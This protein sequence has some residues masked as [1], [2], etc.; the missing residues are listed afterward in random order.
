V[1]MKKVLFCGIALLFVLTACGL[2]DDGTAGQL[3]S[4]E[5][6]FTITGSSTGALY[7]GSTRQFVVNPKYD[8]TWTVEGADP[9]GGTAITLTESKRGR[10]TVGKDETNRTL[11]VKATSVENPQDF[12]TVTVTIDGIPAVWTELT[13]GLKGLITNRTNGFYWF[14]VGVDDASFGIRV[15]AYGD[16]VGTG[17]G[18]WVLGGGSDLREGLDDTGNGSHLWPVM[19]YSDDDGGTWKEIHTIPA[20]LYEENTLC[21]IYDGPPDDRKFVLSTD[22][23]NVFWSYD[24]ITWTKFLQVHPGYAPANTTDRIRQVLYG[25]IDA[26]GGKGRYLTIGVDSRFTWSD[27]GGKTWVQHY[28]ATD[29]RYMADCDSM[30]VKYGT[31]INGGK[32]VKMFFGAGYLGKPANGV[33]CYSLDGINWV[34]LEEANVA[35]VAFEPNPPAGANKDISWKDE[36]D[37]STLL[38]AT[39]VTEPY[40]WWGTTDTLKEYPGV[41]KHADFVAYGNGKYLAVGK[42]RRLAWTDAETAKK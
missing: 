36:A 37:I 2:L 26:N 33:H 11:T 18:R 8:V 17:N 12:N 38:F 23:G 4:E 22:K 30:L 10:L 3:R 5:K 21:L 35:A 29:W 9:E 13:A 34:M 42:G 7:R 6:L 16:G 41:N 39:E 27:D 28:A 40:T 15:L 19:A 31:G 14:G 25:D 1:I 32:R 24:G 20:L